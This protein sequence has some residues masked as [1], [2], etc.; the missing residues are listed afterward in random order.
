[1]SQDNDTRAEFLAQAIHQLAHGF[2][3]DAFQFRRD[4]FNALNGARQGGKSSTSIARPCVSGFPAAF[5]AGVAIVR[6]ARWRQPDC[7][8]SRPAGWSFAEQ[9]PRELVS[10]RAA[11]PVMA[12]MR[13]TPAAADCS[14]GNFEKADIAG[15]ADV[16]APAQFLAVKTA[17]R[18]GS[19]MVTTR[20]LCS[21]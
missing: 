4:H 11:E 3:V 6:Y 1:M 7:Y 21:G 15:P 16:R 5:R 9:L 10:D 18:E 12:S 14:H 8:R 17:R 19:G 2:A 13:R 20:T